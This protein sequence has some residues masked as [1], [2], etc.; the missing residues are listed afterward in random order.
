M[1][2]KPFSTADDKT[3]TRYY[4]ITTFTSNVIFKMHLNF[5]VWMLMDEVLDERVLKVWAA[6]HLQES[7][8]ARLRLCQP[9]Q[10]ASTHT[11]NIRAFCVACGGKIIKQKSEFP[12]K[13]F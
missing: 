11:K 3:R 13:I 9:P 4:I 5:K 6:T 8:A 1:S 7:E 10:E 2:I 12:C